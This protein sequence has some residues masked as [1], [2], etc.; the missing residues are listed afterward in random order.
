MLVGRLQ[1]SN[2]HIPH[3]FDRGLNLPV[4]PDS[5]GFCYLLH[6]CAASALCCVWTLPL[7]KS[8]TE[9]PD[10]SLLIRL[11]H[12]AS[13]LFQMEQLLMALLEGL[14]DLVHKQLHIPGC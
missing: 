12:N 11:L 10:R 4:E 2:F 5:L 6:P 3:N 13:L 14:L 9:L 7:I 8:Q 1:N